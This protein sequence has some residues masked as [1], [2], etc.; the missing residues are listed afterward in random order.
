MESDLDEFR[1]ATSV[2]GISISL[3]ILVDRMAIFLHL[4]TPPS[5]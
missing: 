2:N 1:T 5:H 4:N 3:Y